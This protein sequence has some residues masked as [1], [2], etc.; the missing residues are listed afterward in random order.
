MPTA[1]PDCGTKNFNVLGNLRYLRK[2]RLGFVTMAASLR[3]DVFQNCPNFF[4]AVGR[5]DSLGVGLRTALA[6]LPQKTLFN[7][8]KRRLVVTGTGTEHESSSSRSVAFATRWKA[9]FRRLH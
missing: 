2:A 4:G 3:L 7:S 9:V 1:A 6:K 8:R 5:E